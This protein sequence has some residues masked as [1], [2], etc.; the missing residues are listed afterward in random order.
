MVS[1]HLHMVL[2]ACFCIQDEYLMKIKRNLGNIV[3]FERRGERYMRVV[4]PK[5]SRIEHF[6]GKVTVDIL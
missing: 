3:K 4:N 5:A 6:C 2:P 1:H